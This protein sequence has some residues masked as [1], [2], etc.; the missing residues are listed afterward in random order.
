MTSPTPPLAGLR[1][2]ELGTGL[3]LAY[4]G[5]LFADFGAEVWKAEATGG[6]P[7]RR[8]AP[9]AGG[10]GAVFAWAN[11]NKRGITATPAR[12]AALLPACDLLL[13]ARAPAERAVNPLGQHLPG[14]VSM[15]ISPFGDS[16]PYRDYAAPD[17]VLRGMAG[18][19]FTTGP[20]AGPPAL[21][22]GEAGAVVGGIAAFIGAAAALH[23][24]AQGGR[25]LETSLL[26]ANLAVAEY[27]IAQA[28]MTPEQVR[29]YGVNKHFPTSPQGVFPCAEGWL[30]VT[31]VTPAQW[32]GFCDM[33]GLPELG[34]DPDLV[35]GPNRMAR[36][37]ELE[38][39]FVPRLLT[40]SAQSWFEEALT[41]RLPFVEVPD[42]A[43]LLALPAHRARGAFGTVEVGGARF[44]GPALPQYLTRTPP[45]RTGR[46]P[47]AGEHDALPVPAPRPQPAAPA[48]GLPLAGMTVLDLSM[49]WAG[50]I[51]TRM[52]GDLGARII[53]VEACAYP[54]WW[55]GVDPR[56]AFF[57]EKQYERNSRFNA[58]NRNKL[59]ITLD[60]TRPEGV[61]LVKRLVRLSDAVVE[62]YAA[63]V[64]PKLGLDYPV[65]RRERPDLV[66]VSM[67][68]FGSTGAWKD[69]RAY[70]STLEHASGL[71]SVSGQADWP[72]MTNHL[73]YGDPVGGH[74]AAA[75]LLVALLHRQASGEGQHIDLS[76]VECMFPLVAPF[77][78]A[79][80]VTGTPG[81]RLGNRHPG[82]VPHG[83]F[84]CVAA[85]SWLA[86]AVQDDAAWAR[87]AGL[88]GREDLAGLPLAA[89]RAREPELEALVAAWTHQRSD[90]AAMA[91]LQAAG[92]AAGVCRHPALLHQDP[93]LVA[94]QVFQPTQRAFV[95]SHLQLS[96][97]F[98]PA[99]GGPLP[100]RSPA[101]TLG[102]HN[103]AVLGEVL[104]LAPAELEGL[105]AAG[106]IGTAAV[107][108]AQR[109]SRAS[110]G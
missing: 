88:L 13:D 80:S 60:L 101:P 79:Q 95:G 74:N 24:R 91:A 59:G 107:P 64:L 67:A 44:E 78:V 26:E 72:P 83:V 102:E 85:D 110:A 21:H 71:P 61:A 55:R 36:A 73:A 76:Q 20:A 10:E 100:V 11:T 33:V 96:S 19:Y 6:D 16:G 17:A 46:A 103:A 32:R 29:R 70:G 89:R 58:Q 45:R 97:A 15:A 18:V 81:G 38:A 93:H 42:M 52:L 109:R 62:N 23:G 3:A 48:T 56:P 98:R 12:L 54:D 43:R 8:E 50:P 25:R 34:H 1:V 86:L 31:I 30:G 51:C 106:I 108:V 92:I 40:R 75:A 14:L 77:I 66:M 9:L 39:Q 2:L 41:R 63:E 82:M 37:A 47:L 90:E 99:G 94:R 104:G 27:H 7:L 49:G 53:K 22:G 84:P 35:V 87:L 105:A 4:C 69:A 65:L 5:K 28:M 68:A 57:A